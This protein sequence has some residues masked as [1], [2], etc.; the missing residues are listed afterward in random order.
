M[1][2]KPRREGE[3]LTR[4]F[5]ATQVWC[6]AV[7]AAVQRDVADIAWLVARSV[8]QYVPRLS[9]RLLLVSRRNAHIELFA[10]EGQRTHLKNQRVHLSI[11]ASSL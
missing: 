2:W 7:R 9:H 4:A 3:W 8:R 10:K 11:R 6:R 5:L 1:R